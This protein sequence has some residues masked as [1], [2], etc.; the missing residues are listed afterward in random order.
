MYLPEFFDEKD[1]AVILD[2]IRSNSF[3]TMISVQQG[4]PFVSHIPLL[5]E[6]RQDRLFLRGHVARANKHW[7][8]MQQNP[9][10]VVLFQGPHCY[11]SPTWYQQPG[12]PTWNYVAVHAHGSASIR[13]DIDDI[14]DIIEQLA[15]S[16]EAGRDQPW[17]LDYPPNMV[18]AIVGF[19]IEVSQLEAK[20]KLS[21][22]RPP[23]D[24]DGV[25]RELGKL[26]DVQAQAMAKLMRQRQTPES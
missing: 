21:Q 12:A 20:F 4:Q 8:I 24:R 14:K 3:A 26:D 6:M 19:E 1:P 10:I 11:V 13:E 2:F 25:M 18:Q 23:Q 22:N 9:D 7:N 17:D 5:I 16:H 15:R